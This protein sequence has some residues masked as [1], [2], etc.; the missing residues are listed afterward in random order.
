MRKYIVEFIGTFFIVLTV[1]LV[2]HNNTV[3]GFEPLAIG[4]VFTALI[5]AGGHISSAHYNP[6]VTLAMFIRKNINL[7]DMIG[8]ILAQVIAAIFGAF[9]ASSLLDEGV[10]NPQKIEA[11]LR[12]INP[13]VVLTAEFLGTF[14]MVYVIMNVATAKANRGNSFYGLAIGAIVTVMIYVFGPISGAAFNPAVA[15]GLS[16]VGQFDWA[17]LWIYLVGSLAGAGVATIIYSYLMVDVDE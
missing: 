4:L 14:V 5:Y 2:C 9:T 3:N 17:N 16:S 1:V 13:L 6:A 7:N 12:V 11:S 10:D 15:I 8:Y